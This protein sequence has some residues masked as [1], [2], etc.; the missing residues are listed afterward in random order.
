MF[1]W[2]TERVWNVNKAEIHLDTCKTS[3]I[4]GKRK[5]RNW[6]LVFESLP[7]IYA[8]EIYKCNAFHSYL[9]STNSIQ[10]PLKSEMARII[11]ITI[12]IS[13]DMGHSSH[14]IY[15]CYHHQCQMTKSPEWSRCTTVCF[16]SHLAR[17][18]WSIDLAHSALSMVQSLLP[19]AAS[20]QSL[21]SEHVTNFIFLSLLSSS[22]MS[23][24]IFVIIRRASGEDKHKGGNC[25]IL[26]KN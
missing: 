26:L 1:W 16:T 8:T 6:K 25:W 17:N 15:L 21:C 3:K 10:L 2:R 11:H 12:C 24:F 19:S 20:L 4:P 7:N 18:H 14:L 5:V 22:S 23:H 9:T 13:I